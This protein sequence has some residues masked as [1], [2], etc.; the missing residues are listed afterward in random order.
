[1][2]ESARP[3]A[4]VVLAKSYEVIVQRNANRTSLGAGAAQGR[5]VRELSGLG[6]IS[7]QRID[8]RAYRPRVDGIVCVAPD[9]SEY[10]AHVQA[11]PTANA[12]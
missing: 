3:L 6:I 4:R 12:P 11:R 9:L 10:G 1:V 2:L 8:D 7:Q 5:C